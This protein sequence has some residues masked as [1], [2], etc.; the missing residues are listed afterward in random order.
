MALVSAT[1]IGMF[2]CTLPFCIIAVHSF[3][4]YLMDKQDPKKK[5]VFYAFLC[6]SAAFILNLIAYI[7]VLPDMSPGRFMA[8]TALFKLFDAVNIA[9]VFWI[10]VFLTDF[11]GGMKRY[12]PLVFIHLGIS[13]VLI[14]GMPYGVDIIDGTNYVKDR[15]AVSSLAILAFWLLYWGIVAYNFWSHS[16]LMTKRVAARRSQM[17]SLGGVFSVLSYLCAI[18]SNVAASAILVHLA[19]FFA[20]AAGIVFYAGFVAP[21]RLR[22][23]WEE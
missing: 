8:V 14:L 13:L 18:F 5:H 10:F 1:T 16:K 12:L 9:G 20:T 11:M 19:L 21:E 4:E 22:R 23:M 2:L 3:R 6:F 7:F 15:A 17:M